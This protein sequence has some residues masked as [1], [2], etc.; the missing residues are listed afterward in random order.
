MTFLKLNQN[1]Y[2]GFVL[3]FLFCIVYRFVFEN[4]SV[5]LN[6]YS[7]INETINTS[8]YLVYIHTATFYTAFFVFILGKNVTCADSQILIRLSRRDMFFKNIIISSF[9][10]II[11][12]LCFFIP[13]LIYM[14][15]NHG[16]SDLSNIK[17]YNLMYIQVLAY[18][19]YYLI[20][21]SILLLVYYLSLNRVLSQLITVALNMLLMF[22]Y[23]ILH[24]KSPIEATLVYTKFY[25]G[26]AE[27]QILL[28]ILH[29]FPIAIFLI[30]ASYVV[31]SAKDVL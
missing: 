9:C 28:Q 3:V 8:G 25:G 15:V 18:A 26:L 27:S 7:V 30:T 21:S 5:P 17:F 1:K 19:L 22:G 13:H 4:I 10:S 2:L 24:I 31:F 20:T 11:F 16:M 23:R 12:S 6:Y 14:Q 29:L